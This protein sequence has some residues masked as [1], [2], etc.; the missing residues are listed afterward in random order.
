MLGGILEC[1]GKRR[2]TPLCLAQ[3]RGNREARDALCARRI[4]AARKKRRRCF[5]L[6][7]QSKMLA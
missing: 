4:T 6:P 7:A 5:A 1:G 2:A 3:P